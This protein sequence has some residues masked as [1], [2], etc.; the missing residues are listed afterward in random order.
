[1]TTPKPVPVGPAGDPRLWPAANE[2]RAVHVSAGIRL[3]HRV[4][5]AASTVTYSSPYAPDPAVLDGH[6]SV[7]VQQASAGGLDI[8]I[9]DPDAADDL[10]A[11]L[12]WAAARLRELLTDT[13]P[14]TD[15]RTFGL[16]DPDR[17]PRTITTPATTEE[18]A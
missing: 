14:A 9:D 16:A 17:L 5:I 13:E 1:M 11:A 3:W 6:L 4:G 2:L 8:V 10:A 7:E 12:T 15:R 18:A